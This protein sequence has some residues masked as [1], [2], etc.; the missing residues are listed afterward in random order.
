MRAAV[1]ALPPAAITERQRRAWS[2]LP[3]LYHR[4]AMGPGDE[5][6]LVAERA[7]RVVGYAALRGPE[8]TA[9]FVRPREQGRGTGRALVEAAAARARAARVRALTV[10][11]ARPAVAFYARLGFRGR[12]PIRVPLPGDVLLPG[13]RMALQLRRAL[14]VPDS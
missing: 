3:A 14:V 5:R 2:S 13:I 10:V 1:R 4:W 7:G 8:L 11:A 12:R 6:Y 9:V